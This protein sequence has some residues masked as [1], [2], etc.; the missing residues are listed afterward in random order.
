[1]IFNEIY[2][3]GAYVVELDPKFDDRGFFARGFCK[4][5]FSDYGIDFDVAQLNI[6]RNLDIGTIRGMHYQSYPAGECKFIRCTKGSIWDVIVDMR[7]NSPTYL[8]HFEIELSEF[9]RKA[10]FIPKLFAHGNQ[11]L[12][13]N[14]ELLYLVSEKY[15]PA[16]ECGVRP[17]DPTLAIEW[18][19]NISRMSTKDKNWPLI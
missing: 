5:E 8:N 13:A 7:P 17:D 4:S 15:Q 12:I 10:I 11:T 6:S 3:K 18:P 16:C 14:S 19:I 2:L 1:M 9:N